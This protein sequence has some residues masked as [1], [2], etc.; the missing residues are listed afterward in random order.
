MCAGCT[1]LEADATVLPLSDG[2]LHLLTDASQL[3]QPLHV[4][5]NYGNG[6]RCQTENTSLM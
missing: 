3:A 5:P 6:S 4:Q 2:E 1:A